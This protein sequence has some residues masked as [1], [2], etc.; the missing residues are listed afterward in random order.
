M[1]Q[2]TNDRGPANALSVGRHAIHSFGTPTAGHEDRPR[3]LT[4]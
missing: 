3:M 4:R 1:R 2:I